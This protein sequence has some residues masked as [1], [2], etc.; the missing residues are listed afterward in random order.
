MGVT[1][2]KA[3]YTELASLVFVTT[4][5]LVTVLLAMFGRAVKSGRLRVSELERDVE[6]DLGPSDG[7][8]GL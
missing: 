1:G 3:E 5:V 7:S 6:C 2:E 8:D 4:V